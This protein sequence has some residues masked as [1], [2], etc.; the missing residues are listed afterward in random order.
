[1]ISQSLFVNRSIQGGFLEGFR[2]IETC[3]NLYVFKK[4]VTDF[5]GVQSI[6][7]HPVKDVFET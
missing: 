5:L 1:M 7:F 2:H 4:I 6:I 3:A